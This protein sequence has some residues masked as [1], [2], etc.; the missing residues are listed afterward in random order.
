MGRGQ[1]AVEMG[2]GE[3]AAEM[4]RGQY[5]SDW[6]ERGSKVQTDVL[7]CSLIT[8]LH[9]SV[10]LLKQP[11]TYLN[12]NQNCTMHPQGKLLI[13]ATPTQLGE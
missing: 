9:L 8:C 6:D 5:G 1:Y 7:K 10:L 3:Y 2:R 11:L 13:V 12:H 4:G